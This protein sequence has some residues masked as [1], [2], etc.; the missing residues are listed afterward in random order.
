MAAIE[1][2]AKTDAAVKA[3]I[4]RDRTVKRVG[5]RA[6]RTKTIP[7]KTN[8]VANWVATARPAIKPNQTPDHRPSCARM[9]SA[10]SSD[11]AVNAMAIV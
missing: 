4:T 1:N 6:R 9:R 10:N 8:A 2:G 5:A 3:A 11:H 7:G